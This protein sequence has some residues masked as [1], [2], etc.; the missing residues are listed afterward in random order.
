[1]QM[2]TSTPIHSID[3]S[4]QTIQLETAEKSRSVVWLEVLLQHMRSTPLPTMQCKLHHSINGCCL[5]NQVRV[6]DACQHFD[7]VHKPASR[8]T[9]WSFAAARVTS[10]G[11]RDW[12]GPSSVHKVL[13][14]L[15]KS[16][17][18]QNTRCIL[19]CLAP[20]KREKKGENCR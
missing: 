2:Q 15:L 9:Q 10:R 11:R 1:M 12:N 13:Q 19:G 7:A 14:H 6:Q 5:A 3:V 4:Q 17:S 8:Q 16:Q 20:K 18:S